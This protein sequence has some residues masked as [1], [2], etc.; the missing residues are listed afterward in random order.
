V[1][2]CGDSTGTA[3]PRIGRYVG[4]FAYR[5]LTRRVA[6]WYRQRFT[7]TRYRGKP[8]LLS[9]DDHDLD[10]RLRTDELTVELDGINLGALTPDGR[11]ILTKVAR[12]MIEEDLSMEQAGRRFGYGRRWCREALDR[13]RGEL[14][15]MLYDLNGDEHRDNGRAGWRA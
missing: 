6:S 2:I 4:A 1:P 5:I 11:Q 13:L 8:T 7:D 10:E 3:P 14:E 9:L 12:P 15:P